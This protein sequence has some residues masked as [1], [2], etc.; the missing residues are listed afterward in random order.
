VPGWL[1]VYGKEAEDGTA[2]TTLPKCADGEMALVREVTSLAEETRPPA[3][4]NEA[5]LLS[6]MEG[7]GK[8]I[9]DD[10]LKEAMKDKGLGTPATRAT[11]IEGLITEEYIL[12][13]GR[14]LH[15]TAKSF[16]L[17]TLL[18]GLEVN[19]LMSAELTAEWEHH[20]AQIEQGH[21][22][23][24]SFMKGIATMAKHIVDQAKRHENDT[25]SGDYVTLRNPCPKCGA[26]I[27][28]NYRRF[29]CSQCEFSVNK[30]IAGRIMA[31]KKW[32]Q[33]LKESITS[34]LQGFRSKMGRPFN[35]QLKMENATV[36][37]H[38]EGSAPGAELE[39]VS[40][41]VLGNCPKCGHSVLE[42]TRAFACERSSGESR[43]CDFRMGK[44]ILKRDIPAE[45][46]QK[47]LSTGKTD[48]LDKFISKKGRPFKAFLVQAEGGKIG[49]EFENPTRPARGASKEPLDKVSDK[50][51]AKPA[52]K[53]AVKASPKVPKVAGEKATTSRKSTVR[54]K[55]KA[56]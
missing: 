2:E 27:H 34:E 17:M 5:T 12:R 52:R 35:A 1:E 16:S 11:V 13:E 56:E 20:L 43:N 50:K 30:V 54:P 6:A 55:K 44:Q 48:L 39:W 36:T 49:F 53:S 38:F 25:L 37:F 21:Y 51:T 42:S 41:E 22:S 10:E 46:V 29:Q 23:R 19:D 8:L 26:T 24:E 18:H 40:G 32:E 3:R 28:E 15:A 45:Q 14:N 47:L 4:F 7:A 31:A 33:L 9:D